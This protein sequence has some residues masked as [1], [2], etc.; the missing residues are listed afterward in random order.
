MLTLLGI[1][2]SEACQCGELGCWPGVSVIKLFL[3]FTIEE[4]K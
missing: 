2:C 4:A 3:F 1:G